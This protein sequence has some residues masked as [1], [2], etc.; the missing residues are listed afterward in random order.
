[1]VEGTQRP[2]VQ[3]RNAANAERQG[4]ALAQQQRNGGERTGRAADY[5]DSWC[6]LSRQQVC[7]HLEA[8]TGKHRIGLQ[9][10]V[11]RD[12]DQRCAGDPLRHETVERLVATSGDDEIVRDI[13]GVAMGSGVPQADMPAPVLAPRAE[14]FGGGLH[15]AATGRDAGMKAIA[16]G[17]QQR[18]D[19]CQRNAERRA[20]ARN[21][22]RCRML[23]KRRDR[24][25]GIAL[26]RAQ[27]GLCRRIGCDGVPAELAAADRTITLD[28]HEAARQL[29]QQAVAARGGEHRGAR[30]P[31]A[32][33]HGFH[34]CRS[35]R[36]SRT[37]L[38]RHD[39][40]QRLH[41][42][43]HIIGRHRVGERQRQE[44]RANH[45]GDRCR[46]DLCDAADPRLLAEM[47]AEIFARADPFLIQ[48]RDDCIALVGAFRRE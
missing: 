4:G 6:A 47:R 45:V 14:R 41:Y 38:D 16:D 33:D 7:D 29:G 18:A 19:L 39:S 28:D 17:A 12:L 37:R 40:V 42:A 2:A 1:M 30:R 46:F 27:K 35:G 48:P 20:M 21:G 3:E 32:D 10:A 34:M 44:A 36:L 22:E 31:A 23:G 26:D 15:R 11:A 43:C 5:R 8:A 25:V 13:V 9:Q 24:G